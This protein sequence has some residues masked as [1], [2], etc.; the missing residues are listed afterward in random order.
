MFD[1]I[2]RDI[3]RLRACSS[4][5]ISKSVFGGLANSKELL[6]CGAS[7]SLGATSTS[8]CASH[9]LYGWMHDTGHGTE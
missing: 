1:I 3:R 7:G 6:K 8:A 2:V 5:N 4:G 9:T